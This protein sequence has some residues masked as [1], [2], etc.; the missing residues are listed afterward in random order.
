MKV[1]ALVPI[2][3]NSQRLPHK[4]ILP[5]AGHPLCWHI[6]HAL[7][8]V[9]EID[10]VYVFC[11]D[12]KV[13]EYIPE[14]TK[15]LIRN[16]RLDHDE[17]KGFEIYAEFIRQVDADVYVLAHTTSPLIQPKTIK[18]ALGHVLDGSHDSAF[19][20]Q[21]IQT[22]AWYQGKPVN[23]DIND[24]PR[25][26]DMEPVYVETSAFFIFEKKIFT[27]HHR[28]IGFSPY[29]Q[30]VS[31]IEAVDIDERKDYEFAL[32]LIGEEAQGLS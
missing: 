18:N 22:F 30:E 7:N 21:K 13:K 23:Y 9:K 3:L 28:R 8:E 17:V 26:Q 11:S 6:C 24:V 31:D 29:I 5:I 27:K 4:N 16:P 32:R 2:K 20:A 25:T 19:S 12:E 15:L 10:E 1:V 14:E